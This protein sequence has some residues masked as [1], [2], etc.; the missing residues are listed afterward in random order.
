LIGLISCAT[1][2]AD[3]NVAHTANA[4]SSF[5]KPVCVI[6]YSSM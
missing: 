3:T 2:G 4:L 1:D 5:L 6:V